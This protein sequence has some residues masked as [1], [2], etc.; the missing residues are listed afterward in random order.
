MFA[1]PAKGQNV[2]SRLDVLR[3]PHLVDDCACEHQENKSADGGTRRHKHSTDT[4][5]QTNRM[6]RVGRDV[7]LKL[8]S[9]AQ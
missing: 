9:S 2:F 1:I 3:H 5:T 6:Q 8:K 4:S 7:L